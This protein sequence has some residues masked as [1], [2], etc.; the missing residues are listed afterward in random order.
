MKNMLKKNS[1]VLSLYDLFLIVGIIGL[2]LLYSFLNREFDI[3]GSVASITGVLCVVLVAKRS[4]WNYFFGVINVSLY[5]Y[6]SYKSKLYGDALLN[7]LYY[8]PMQ[9]VGWYMWIKAKGGVTESGEVSDSIVKSKMMSWKLRVALFVGCAILVIIGGY[10]LDN[11]TPDEYPYKDSFT[12]ILSV[13]AMML[14]VWKYMEQWMI[15]IAVNIVSVYIWSHA[16]FKGEPHAG[17]MA[18]MWLFY[19][20]NSINGLRVWRKAAKLEMQ[21]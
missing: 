20:A 3:M 19:L 15:W 9:F 5:A 10:I 16:F 11:Y 14:M 17:V 8:F 21:R 18:L 6:I 1:G 4:I 12:T 7:A 2:N 13:V